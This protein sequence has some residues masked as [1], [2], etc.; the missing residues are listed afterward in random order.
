MTRPETEASKDVLVVVADT[1][2]GAPSIERIRGLAEGGARIVAW[3]HPPIVQERFPSPHVEDFLEREGLPAESLS[4]VL[5]DDNDIEVEEAVIAWFKAFGR[6]PL[7]PGGGFRDLFRYRGMSLWWWAELWLYHDTPLRLLV[8]DVEALKRLLEREQPR[9]LVLVAPVRRLSETAKHLAGDVEILGDRILPS[10]PKRTSLRF[11][12]IFLKMLG[13]GLKALLSPIRR[14]EW[15]GRPRFL[16]LSHAS[17][18]RSRPIEDSSETQDVDL[19]FDELPQRLVSEGYGVKMVAVGPRIP[20]KQRHTTDVLKEAL[21]VGVDRAGRYI[22][23]RNYFTP[24]LAFRLAVASFRCWGMWRRFRRLPELGRALQHHGVHI[25][26]Q[27]LPPFRDTFLLQLPWVVRS[28]H[29]IEAALRFEKPDLLVLY[30]EYT[31]LGRAAVAAAAEAGIPS[32]ALQHGILYPRLYA[33]EHGEDEVSREADG[34]DGV[35]LPTCTAVFGSMAR[36]LLTE[37]GNYP[38]ER[39][40]IT[41]SPKFDALVQA[42]GRFDREATRRR[43][44]IDPNEKMLVVASRWSAIGPVFADLVEACEA[45]PGLR[46][47]VKPHQAEGGYPY[48]ETGDRKQATR[49]CIV[50]P[51]DDLMEHLFASDGLVTVDSFASSEALMLGRPV[52]VVNL[53]SNLGALVKRGVALGAHRGQPVEDLLRRML[54]DEEYA[55]AFEQMRREYLMEFA[56]GADGRSTTRIVAALRQVAEKGV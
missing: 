39:I 16:F 6:V 20:F 25:G 11:W 13:T 5:G 33:N 52:L 14:T 4:R 23:I 46:L 47:V 54:F 1:R 31:A 36:D 37:R 34:R 55:R 9:R 45:I 30:A 24:A 10:R 7:G 44:E 56:F 42:E 8:R 29:E 48:R 3:Q 19:Y 40:V 15:T 50:P 53:P 38:P 41:G 12:T 49:M 2:V 43:L 21:E 32:F 18:W 35:P 17:M 51:E 27:A 22:P 26:G 28:F